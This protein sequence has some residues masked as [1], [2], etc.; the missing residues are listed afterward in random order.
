MPF[1][2]YLQFFI[3][4]FYFTLLPLKSKYNKALCV[5]TI[6]WVYSIIR[7]NLSTWKTKRKYKIG[8]IVCLLAFF[9]LNQ[10]PTAAGT[11]DFQKA[12]VIR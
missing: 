9:K 3:N 7:S 4:F 8:K 6:V 11:A 1:T 12:I 5:G 10:K 2:I